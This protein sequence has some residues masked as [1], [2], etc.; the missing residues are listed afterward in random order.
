LDGRLESVAVELRPLSEFRSLIVDTSPEDAI[1]EIEV[2][3]A[4]LSAR[5]E[6][7]ALSCTR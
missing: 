4:M 6:G 5:F 2:E 7:E 3:E 1:V